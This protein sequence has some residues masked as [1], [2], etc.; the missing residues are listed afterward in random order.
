MTQNEKEL[1][2]QLQTHIERERSLRQELQMLRQ[3]LFSKKQ[4]EKITTN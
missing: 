3:M 4:A 2:Q 1:R